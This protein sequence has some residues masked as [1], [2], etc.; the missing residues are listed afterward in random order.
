MSSNDGIATPFVLHLLSCSSVFTTDL[1]VFLT[2]GMT[3]P[4]GVFKALPN[5]YD[6][7]FCKNS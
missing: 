6:K 1:N 3:I 2:A 4:R 7:K 5:V